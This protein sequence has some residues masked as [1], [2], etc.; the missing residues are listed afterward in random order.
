MLKE[1]VLGIG[2]LGVLSSCNVFG[3]ELPEYTP[4]AM[5]QI[6]E[7]LKAKESEDKRYY[8]ADMDLD[9]DGLKDVTVY[10]LNCGDVG[11]S[12]TK[13]LGFFDSFRR[14]WTLQK[15]NYFEKDNHYSDPLYKICD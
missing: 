14:H 5:I 3:M 6:G 1:M 13:P 7:T 8:V 11:K 2:T 9:D 10:Y 4:R 12:L 15:E